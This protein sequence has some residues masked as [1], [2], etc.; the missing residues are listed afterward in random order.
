[1]KPLRDILLN[2]HRSVEPKLDRMW[3][4]T[5]APELRGEPAPERRNVLLA[6]GLKLWGELIWPSRRVWAGLAC[7]WVLL[8]A[9]NL[10]SSDTTQRVASRTEPPTGMEFQALIEQRRML[11]Q[12]IEPTSEPSDKRRRSLPG[13][14]SDR[15]VGVFAA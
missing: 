11:A 10:A 3:N 15:P 13:P 9:W 1:M 7:V 12:L 5:L 8:I 4:E 2:R 6:V 14:R